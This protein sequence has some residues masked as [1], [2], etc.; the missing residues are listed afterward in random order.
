MI[1]QLN[2]PE[3]ISMTNSHVLP[4]FIEQAIAKIN[5]HHSLS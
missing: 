4:N 5:N 2:D 3:K 1:E